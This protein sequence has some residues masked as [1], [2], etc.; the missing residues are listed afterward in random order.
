MTIIEEAFSAYE[1]LH[2][3]Q[4]LKKKKSKKKLLEVIRMVDDLSREDKSLCAFVDDAIRR[5]WRIDH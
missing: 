3:W 4:F 2:W 1:K 5:L